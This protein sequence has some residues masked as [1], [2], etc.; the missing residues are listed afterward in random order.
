[1]EY[2]S[3]L[4]KLGLWTFEERR[5][6]R[7]FKMYTGLSILTFDLLF[8]VSNNSCTRGQSFK[9]AKHH[10]RLDPRKNFFSQNESLT[11]WNSLDQQAVDSS[12]MKS[13]K[14][15]LTRT[16]NAKMGFFMDHSV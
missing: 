3:R 5:D 13:F 12:S 9:L 14:S 2:E 8:E 10:C 11:E 4:Q 6:L 1:M 7:G 15:A 16:R